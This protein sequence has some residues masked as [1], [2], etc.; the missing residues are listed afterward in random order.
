LGIS[1]NQ[2]N[3]W[4]KNEITV[5]RAWSWLISSNT[6]SGFSGILD[7]NGKKKKN[8][9]VRLQQD[10]SNYMQEALVMFKITSSYPVS[11]TR[12]VW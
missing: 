6:S 7:Y 8:N 9:Q 4:K 10:H 11:Q 12:G 3:K 2:K 5:F 1:E